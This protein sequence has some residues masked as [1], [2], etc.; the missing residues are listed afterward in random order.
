MTDETVEAPRDLRRELTNALRRCTPKQRMYLR[1]VQAGAGQ[2]WSDAVRG[3]FSRHTL[4]KWLR[5]ERVQQVLALHAEIAELDSDLTVERIKREVG[6]LAF[7]NFMEFYGPDGRFKPPAQWTEEMFAAVEQLEFDA[8]GNVLK[9]K[10][11]RKPSALDSA[12]KIRGVLVERHKM[13]IT[14]ELTTRDISDKPLSPEEWESQYG[15]ETPGGPAK[16]P[17]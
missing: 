12:A 9:I 15:L 3:T 16:G 13:D 6:R 4:Q 14:G 8:A 1:R 2:K 11:Y 17:R 10:L 5:M 7:S